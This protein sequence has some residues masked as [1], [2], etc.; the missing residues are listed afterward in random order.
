MT[1]D[2][3]FVAVPLL[4]HFQLTITH[5]GLYEQSLLV[6]FQRLKALWLFKDGITYQTV[7]FLGKYQEN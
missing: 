3:T 5:S 7:P 2:A 4:Y 1:T 6:V